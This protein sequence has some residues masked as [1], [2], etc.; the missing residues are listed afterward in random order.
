L[1]E[2]EK[3]RKGTKREKGIGKGTKKEWKGEDIERYSLYV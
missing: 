2:K 3:H 1:N